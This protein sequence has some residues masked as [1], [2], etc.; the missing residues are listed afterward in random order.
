MHWIIMTSIRTMKSS[1]FL[2]L[3]VFLFECSLTASSQNTRLI[4]AKDAYNLTYRITRIFDGKVKAFS[5]DTNGVKKAIIIDYDKEPL[6]GSENLNDYIS[7]RLIYPENFDEEQSLTIAVFID[8][9]GMIRDIRAL[10]IIEKCP[11]CESLVKHILTSSG[12]W[13]PAVKNNCFVSSQ[14]L[15]RVFYHYSLGNPSG[16]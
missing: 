11:E 3:F 9:K 6:H 8:D 14:V 7:N 15:V 12:K 1:K 13:Q 2:G 10:N 16:N 5:V 4:N